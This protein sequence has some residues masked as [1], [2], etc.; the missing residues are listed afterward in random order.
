MGEG[1]AHLEIGAGLFERA[2]VGTR[3]NHGADERLHRALPAVPGAARGSVFTRNTTAASV[4]SGN[5]PLAE[6]GEMTCSPPCT[7]RTARCS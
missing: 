4:R 5:S 3:P 2:A 1:G 6:P 7:S